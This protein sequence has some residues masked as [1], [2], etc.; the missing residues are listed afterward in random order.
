MPKTRARLQITPWARA[1]ATL[2]LQFAPDGLDGDRTELLEMTDTHQRLR[3]CKRHVAQASA[4]F[5]GG[6]GGSGGG[7]GCAI[8]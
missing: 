5:V 3:W 6:T 2:L 8:S 1:Q 4:R 7:A